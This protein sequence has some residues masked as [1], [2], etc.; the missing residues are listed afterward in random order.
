MLTSLRCLISAP[1]FTQARCY[2]RLY[3][4]SHEW[5]EVK[6]DVGTVGIS[7]HAQSALGDIVF[8]ASPEVDAS[9][10]K[11]DPVC[12]V[13]SVKA[14]AQIYSPVSGRIIEFNSALAAEPELVNKSP[15][16][17]GWIFRVKLSDPSETK[18]LLDAAKYSALPH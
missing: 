13:E 12:E 15:E 10:K 9:F 7:D 5:V 8:I 18:T 3:T 17:Q 6:G 2:A 1:T 11:G 14:V 4:P 16:E